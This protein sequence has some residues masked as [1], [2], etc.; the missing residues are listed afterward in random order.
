[1]QA[2]ERP[3]LLI[4]LDGWGINKN[5]E[6]N[7]IA[8]ARKPFYNSLIEDYPNTGLLA[9]GEAVGL[10]EGQ[11]GNSE[12]GHLN[13]GAGRVVYQDLTRINRSIRDGSFYN[14]QALINGIKAA[15]SGNNRLHLLGLLSDG[16]VHSSI[17]H[18][19]SLIKM[20]KELSIKELFF[21]VILDGRDTPPF[22]GLGYT[23]R[24]ETEIDKYGIGTIAT[25]MGRYYAMDRDNRWDRIEKA[26]DAMVTGIGEAGRSAKEIINRNY[27]LGIGDE[28]VV[29]SVILNERGRPAGRIEDGDSVIFFNFRADRA[30]EITRA[31]TDKGFDE[32]KRGE[33]PHLSSFVC[34]TCYDEGFDL[35]VAFRKI[36]LD[37]IFPEVIS[38]LGLRQMRIAETEKYAHVTYFFNGGDEK[39]YPGEERVLIPSPRDVPTYDLKPEM[40][41][42]EVTHRAT[43]EISTDLYKFILVNYAN[44][45]MV[46]HTGVMPAAIRAVEVIDECLSMLITAAKQK[47]WIVFI[48]ADHG[49]I[50]QVADSDTNEPLTAHTLNKVPLIIINHAAICLRDDGILADVAPTI[51]DI[52]GIKKPEEM[53]GNSLIKR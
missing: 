34:M 46:G 16:G 33:P 10:P 8:L 25:I 41:A 14:N 28:F 9:A 20:T 7:A 3:L 43:K 38:N 39:V 37:N 1:M 36:R 49:N 26:Y 23:E 50:E 4:V 27:S 30:R 2:W 22:S 12:V 19:F 6:G 11:M 53:S 21:H 15:L 18:L 35:P 5:H 52:M 48:T 17:D 44:P 47:G 45:D 24:L 40:S 51:M 13:L 29:P 42:Y 32:F 31:L